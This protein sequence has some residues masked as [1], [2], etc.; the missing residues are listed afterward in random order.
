[1]PP[2]FSGVAAKA[3]GSAAR[4]LGFGGTSLPGK[5]YLRLRPQGL[6]RLRGNLQ[7]VALIS[8]TNGKTTTAALARSILLAA[9][10]TVVSNASGANMAGGIATALLEDPGGGL[11]L[12]EVDELWL[13]RVIG[14]L[15]PTRVVLGNL[16]RDQLDRYGE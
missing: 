5:V 4:A 2:S 10:R 3:A 16:L 14:E 1:M 11:G 9:G 12:F 8:A 7:G 13:P 15:A 6:G